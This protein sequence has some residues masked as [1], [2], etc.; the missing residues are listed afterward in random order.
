MNSGYMARLT[1]DPVGFIVRG[2]RKLVWDP[3]LYRRGADYDAGRYWGDRFARYGTALRGSGHEAFSEDWNAQAYEEAGELL[4][5][6]LDEKGF[7]LSGARVLDVGCGP[8]FYTRVCWEHETLSYLGLDITPALLPALQTAF[9]RFSFRQHDITEEELTGCYDLVLLIDVAEHIVTAAKL[10]RAL[11]HL[12]GALSVGG[13]LLISLPLRA[14][15]PR[16]LFY[17][18]LWS[19]ND[20][21]A[22]LPGSHLIHSQPFRDGTLLCFRRANSRM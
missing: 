22:A 9:P 7:K 3:L 17:L 15:S 6:L 20:I 1:H 19:L 12:E 18:R 8:G 11:R 14:Q 2:L 4:L 5:E 16:Q 21:V 13:L 10:H